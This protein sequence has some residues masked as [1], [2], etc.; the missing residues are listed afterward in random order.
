MGAITS[1]SIM[2]IYTLSNFKNLTVYNSLNNAKSPKG[3][4]KILNYNPLVNQNQKTD[5]KLPIS[6]R[7]FITIQK[8]R[9]EKISDQHKNK[10]SWANS[11][12]PCLMSKLSSN[13]QLL[14]SLLSATQLFFF[15]CFYFL[16]AAFLGQ[17]PMALASLTS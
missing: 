15:G 14:S 9:G 4:S 17:F 5:H 2:Q 16:L 13:L 1:R 3:S 8:H 11:A 10:P 12:S 6:C 7:I